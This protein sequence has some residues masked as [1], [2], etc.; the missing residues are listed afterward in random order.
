MINGQYWKSHM[1]VLFRSSWYKYH[2]SFRFYQ[3]NF[4][5]YRYTPHVVVWMRSFDNR[6]HKLYNLLV[7][8]QYRRYFVK[9]YTYPDSDPTAMLRAPW[10]TSLRCHGALGVTAATLRRVC[11]DATGTCFRGDLAALVLS[12]FKTWRRPRRS[13]R[14]HCD[15]RR[16]HGALWDLTTTQRRPGRFC[17]SQRGRCSVWLGYKWISSVP[18]FCEFFSIVNTQVSYW[19]SRLSLTGVVAAQLRWHLS[20]INVVQII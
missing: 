7:P 14:P 20:N 1:I 12:M 17:R 16:C 6:N 2:T 4:C 18:S 13:W 9:F 11:C 19:I 5:F 10:A 8:R 15:L 3:V